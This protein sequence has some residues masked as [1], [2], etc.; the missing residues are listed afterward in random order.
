MLVVSGALLVIGQLR[1]RRYSTVMHFYWTHKSFIELRELEFS[2][3]RKV[4]RACWLRPF[5]HWQTWAAFVS[6]SVLILIGAFLGLV[7]DG[8]LW[9]LRGDTPLVP[10][11]FR[12]PLATLLLALAGAFVGMFI[13][14]QVYASMIRPELKRY[15]ETHHDA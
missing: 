7:A 9:M 5:C 14:T 8:Q 3:R 15:L 12:F 10:E 4:W 2:R 11:A 13:F 1:V 6:Q